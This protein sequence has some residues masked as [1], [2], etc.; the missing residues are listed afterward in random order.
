MPTKTDVLKFLHEAS[1][2]AVSKK[3]R[4]H[5]S[6]Y[7]VRRDWLERQL[8]KW[9]EISYWLT[10]GRMKAYF[11]GN[12][13][14]IDF[15]HTDRKSWVRSSMLKITGRGYII[16]LRKRDWI[17]SKLI[18]FLIRYNFYNFPRVWELTS[19]WYKFRGM[20]MAFV[21]KEREQGI[22]FY[23]ELWGRSFVVPLEN[24]T[25]ELLDEIY[26]RRKPL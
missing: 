12:G 17:N 25:P 19:K 1:Q 21:R 16:G 14:R 8:N 15:W 6:S 11:T 5:I 2:T 18:A 20:Q 26:R 24:L 22:K 23:S 9:A 7:S 4:L 3:G 10:Q 13:L